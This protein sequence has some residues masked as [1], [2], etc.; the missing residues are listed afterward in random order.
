[1]SEKI[2]TESWNER[3]LQ[4]FASD[5]T[6]QEAIDSY[7]GFAGWVL[8]GVLATKDIDG[9]EATD[10]DCLELIS[11]LVGKYLNAIENGHKG[12]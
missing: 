11:G 1:M 6:L 2:T 8:D 9:D 10:H 12:L 4:P 7:G 5:D 3:Y